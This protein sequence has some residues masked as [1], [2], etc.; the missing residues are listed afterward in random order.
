M[1]EALEQVHAHEDAEGDCPEN[2]PE[3]EGFHDSHDKRRRAKYLWSEGQLEECIRKLRV[4]QRES[5]ETE[6]W[7]GVGDRTKDKFDG[8][9]H[10]VDEDGA[11][12]F[13][14]GASFKLF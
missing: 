9:D 5:P 3:E 8:F 14:V 2:G 1:Q 13:L 11:E 6:V 12:S 10:L 4:R 7:S